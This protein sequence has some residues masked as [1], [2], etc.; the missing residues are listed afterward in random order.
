[1]AIDKLLSEKEFLINMAVDRF[2]SQYGSS[3]DP[4][5]FVV[6][7][8]PSNYQMER[9][10]EVVTKVENNF[11][12]LRIYFNITD[13]ERV[14]PYRLEVDD[15]YKTGEHG[16]EVYVFLGSVSTHY[17]KNGTY[18]FRWIERDVELLS[19]LRYMSGGFIM[20][21]SGGHL[22]EMP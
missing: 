17:V 21:M 20:L 6:Y 15:T 10:Y 13:V 3:L 5:N 12:R 7:S 2:N 14:R 4:K 22:E 11:L 9:G 16:D 1:M 18:S 8:I 19:R